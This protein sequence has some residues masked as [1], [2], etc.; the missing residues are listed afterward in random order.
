MHP[1]ISNFVFAVYILRAGSIAG[2]QNS[3]ASKMRELATRDSIVLA[4][5]IH[6][7]A[8]AAARHQSTSIDAATLCAAEAERGPDGGLA[9]VPCGVIDR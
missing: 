4:M 2:Q 6:P 8:R 7:D 5:E 3:D 9:G 1:V